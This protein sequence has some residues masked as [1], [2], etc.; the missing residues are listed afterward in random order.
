MQMSR[1][2][3]SKVNSLNETPQKRKT[4]YDKKNVNRVRGRSG[5][6]RIRNLKTTS[7]VPDVNN[8]NE[9]YENTKCNNVEKKSI[10]S[11]IISRF[12]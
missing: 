9:V 3:K 1:S 11:K 12:R 6:S 8:C 7:A 2:L 5:T 10:L 4:R